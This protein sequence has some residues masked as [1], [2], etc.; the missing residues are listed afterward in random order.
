M[1]LNIFFLI[2]IIREVEQ[3]VGAFL[4]AWVPSK[5]PETRVLD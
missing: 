2:C 4:P 3:C 1:F 5:S